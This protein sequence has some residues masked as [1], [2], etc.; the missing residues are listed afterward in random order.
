[1]NWPELI[2]QLQARGL[3]QAELARRCGVAQSTVSDLSG[4]RTKSPSF[5]LGA[6]LV[7]LHK[8]TEPSQPGCKPEATAHA[9]D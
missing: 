6:A 2:K 1:M 3:T 8:E 9:A 4:G 7:R 5:E